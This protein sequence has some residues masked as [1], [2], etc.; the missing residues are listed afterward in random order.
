MVAQRHA[1]YGPEDRYE[2]PPPA[3]FCISVFAIV[4]KGAK[5]LVGQP[6]EHPRW[7]EDWVPQFRIYPKEDYE[8]V[9]RTPRLPSC[10]L[11]EGEH[12]EAALQ[13]VLREQVG[14][15]QVEVKGLDVSSWLAPS[16]WYPGHSH[17]DLCFAYEVRAQPPAKPKAWWSELAWKDPK[18]LKAKDF[19]WNADL[20][21]ALG[22]AR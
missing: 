21:Q 13:R 11:R 7:L 22:L 3:G 12:P 19:G 14:A 6:A 16:D 20:M 5:V 18:A 4:R 10:Y 8:A 9:W 1:R 2:A 17:W 15:R